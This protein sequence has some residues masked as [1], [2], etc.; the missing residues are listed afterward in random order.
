MG[1][2]RAIIRWEVYHQMLLEEAQRLERALAS[3]AEP[4]AEASEK[5]MRERLAELQSK[6]HALG[7]SPKAKMG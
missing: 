4:A 6:R 2:E 1:R 3:S 7:P 5:S